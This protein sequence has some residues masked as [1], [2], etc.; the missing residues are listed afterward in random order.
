M[1][2]PPPV[3]TGTIQAVLAE[4]RRKLAS[5]MRRVARVIAIR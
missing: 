4:R 1:P 3:A 5:A 2:P